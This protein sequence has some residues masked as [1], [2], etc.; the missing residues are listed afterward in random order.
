MAGR[1]EGTISTLSPF[2]FLPGKTAILRIGLPQ[3]VLTLF[4]PVFV[5]QTVLLALRDEG[6]VLLGPSSLRISASSASLR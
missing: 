4:S 2:R 5:A 3:S 1:A 6:S